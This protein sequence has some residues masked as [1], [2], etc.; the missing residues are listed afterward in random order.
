MEI[1]IHS[2]RKK[3]AD[4]DKNPRGFDAHQATSPM[5]RDA[6]SAPNPNEFDIAFRTFLL[7]DFNGTRS[8]RSQHL[9]A[10]LN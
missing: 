3:T 2:S 4:R 8:D 1:I 9:P 10:C 7:R 6:F 5:I